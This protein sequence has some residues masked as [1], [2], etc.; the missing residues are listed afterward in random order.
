VTTVSTLATSSPSGLFPESGRAARLRE[1]DVLQVRCM[2][3]EFV[4]LVERIGATMISGVRIVDGCVVS[5]AFSR[6]MAAWD[7]L[8]EKG[9]RVQFILRSVRGWVGKPLNLA[10]IAQEHDLLR[11]LASLSDP[12]PKGCEHIRRQAQELLSKHTG[13]LA[14]EAVGNTAVDNTTDVDLLRD[15]I[16]GVLAEDGEPEYLHD[17]LSRLATLDINAFAEVLRGELPGIQHD[18]IMEYM[19]SV[20]STCS[21][22]LEIF[23]NADLRTRCSIESFLPSTV[24]KDRGVGQY[25]FEQAVTDDDPWFALFLWISLLGSYDHELA[26]PLAA[27]AKAAL[28]RVNAGERPDLPW[29]CLGTG[30]AVDTIYAVWF[31]RLSE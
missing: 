11:A 31:P 21:D 10:T 15:T 5:A 16:M 26:R 23:E 25:I 28:E 3:E 7:I 22:L 6:Q 24:W 20:F 8:A 2:G 14:Q 19:T 18:K 13:N 27:Q 12:L 4:M 9:G 17:L 1:D 29:E 30:G